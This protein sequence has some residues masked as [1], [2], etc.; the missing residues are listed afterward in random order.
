MPWIDEQEPVMRIEDHK[1][2][3]FGEC[4]RAMC[5]PNDVLILEQ[6]R[7]LTFE[8]FLKRIGAVGTNFN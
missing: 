3:A 4:Y 1:L 5:G 6:R 8:G 2:E 7:P